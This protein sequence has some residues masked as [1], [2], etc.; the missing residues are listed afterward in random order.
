MLLQFSE[1]IL[2]S[3]SKSDGGIGPG[4]LCTSPDSSISRDIDSVNRTRFVVVA[5]LSEYIL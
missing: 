5:S 4:F 1:A 3:V 2:K